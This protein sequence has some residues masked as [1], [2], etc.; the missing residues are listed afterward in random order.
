MLKKYMPGNI[1]EG[2]IYV[3][4]FHISPSMLQ[5]LHTDTWMVWKIDI[6]WL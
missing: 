1:F 3:I 6:S 2:A 4:S 5:F